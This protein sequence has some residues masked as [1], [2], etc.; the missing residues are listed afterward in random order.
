MELLT[1]SIVMIAITVLILSCC[2]LADVDKFPPTID[3]DSI[4]RPENYDIPDIAFTLD[5]IHNASAKWGFF[6]VIN[7]GVSQ[8]LQDRIFHQ[9]KIFF[10]S[11]REIKDTVRRSETN[12]R[13]YADLEYTKQ[14]IDRKEVFDV[15][16]FHMNTS[17]LSEQAKK[18][19][20][21]DGVNFWP[22]KNVLPEFESTVAEYYEAITNLAWTILRASALSMRCFPQDFF[23]DKFD[24]HTS[25][26]RLNYYPLDMESTTQANEKIDYEQLGV[27]HHTDAG[28]ITV[29]LQDQVGGLE[30]YTGTKEANNDGRWASVPPGKGAITINIGDMLQ[31]SIWSN[32]V[33]KAAEHRVVASKAADRYSVPFF[34]NPNYDTVISPLPCQPEE[35][36]EAK[37]RFKPVRWGDF[38]SER[39]LGDFAN[40]GEEIQIEQFKEEL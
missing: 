27:G 20:A 39:Y 30:A 26:L 17:R 37:P 6:N 8:D 33:Y 19:Y 7:H 25:L 29:L 31:A 10:D 21:L 2:A 32:N 5:E 3:I 16:P 22:D 14:R 1:Q 23:E 34:F 18:D 40:R 38:R 36:D 9:M 35:V 15:G 11:P 24:Q 4:I 13:G 12:S 28:G